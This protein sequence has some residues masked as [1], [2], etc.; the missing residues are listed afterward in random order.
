[1]SS[2]VAHAA[3]LAVVLVATAAREPAQAPSA[4]TDA[5]APRALAPRAPVAG[6]AGFEAVSRLHY[7]ADQK[8][9]HELAC[10]YVFPDRARWQL[11]VRGEA[12]LGRHIEYRYG[13]DY[14]VLEQGRDRSLHLAAGGPRESERRARCEMLELRRAAFLWPDGYAWTASGAAQ[15]S[16]PADCGRTLM[17]ELGDDGRPRRMWLDGTAE[18]IRVQEWRQRG[19]RWWPERLELWSG[20]EAVWTEQ[21]EAVS[22]SLAVLDLYFLPTDRRSSAAPGAASAVSHFD[23]PE[24][25]ERRIELP[26][27]SD[28][29]AA[30]VAWTRESAAWTTTLPAGWQPL[31]GAWIEVA[32]DGTPLA[33]VLRAR[34]TGPAPEGIGRVAQTQALLVST[35]WPAT[36]LEEPL[37]TLQRATPADARVGRWLLSLPDGWEATTKAQLVA[38]LAPAK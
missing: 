10:T 23:A 20:A 7:A 13:A 16:A 28:W 37:R 9:E 30:G 38:C 8:T 29:K 12:E 22:T 5:A 18:Q 32:A 6:L 17:A 35:A 36:T 15:R 34:G 4:T 33:L 3:V 21:V 24:A 31:A 1:M 27:P 25:W 26:R 14:F 11:R 19:A 2:A